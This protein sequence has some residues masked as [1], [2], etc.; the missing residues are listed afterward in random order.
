MNVTP[1]QLL[2]LHAIIDDYILT[3]IPVGSRTLA[4]RPDLPYSS[5]TIRNEM[6]DLEEEGYLEQPHTSA[7][8]LPSDK[9][10]RLYV[11]TLMRVSSLQDEE[12]QLIRQY[13]SSR[14]GEIE[15]VIETTAKVL[16]DVTHMTS[17]VLAPQLSKIELKRIQIVRISDQKAIM[18]FV[19]STGMVKDVMIDIAGD[20]DNAYLE[21]ISNLLTDKVSNLRLSEAVEAVR[22][23]IPGDIEGHR[24]F[25]NS[26]L[27]AV[28]KNIAPR[29]GKEVV[30]GGTKNIFNHPEYRDVSKAQN[31]LQLLETKDQLYDMLTRAT[32]MEFTIKIGKE[33][34]IDELKDMSVV[35]A[36]YKVGD[37]KI[38]SFGVIGPTRMNYGKVLSI[39]SCVGASMN[40]I[41]QYCLNMDTNRK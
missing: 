36:T 12:I 11:D 3:G 20:M 32:D 13:F 24:L 17:L 37:K 14:M 25:L 2:I 31:F 21:M 8:R 7:G 28:R 10:Y 39:M 15:S 18:L 29:A 38:G 30:L 27:D 5:A 16:S 26:M 23:T 9:A 33:N 35:T 41:L 6:A 19:F 1:R 22:S 40:E 4:K 34:E